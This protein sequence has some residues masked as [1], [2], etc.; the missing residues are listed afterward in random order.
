MAFYAY[1][2]ETSDQNNNSEDEELIRKTFESMES[3][4]P[5]QSAA[6]ESLYSAPRYT[7]PYIQ[8]IT[9][10]NQPVSSEMPPVP[11]TGETVRKSSK[12]TRRP[13]WTSD[14]ES[15]API[16]YVSENESLPAY[17]TA[18][19]YNTITTPVAV[20]YYT[21][22]PAYFR[23]A[24]FYTTVPSQTPLQMP[25][26]MP[27]PVPVPIP[28]PV[29]AQMP[30]QVPAPV[31]VQPVPE[32]SEVTS[33]SGSI[34]LSEYP[35]NQDD[36]PEVITKKS[37]QT[38][39]YVQEVSI[40]YLQPPS[41]IP[42]GEILIQHEKPVVPPPAPPIV[43]RQQPPMPET[44]APLVIREAPPKPIQTQERK[45]ITLPGR[46]VPPPPRKVIIE[47]L[48][49]L[50]PK[51]QPLIIERWLPFKYAKRKVIYN[52]PAEGEVFYEKPKNVIIQWESPNVVV[53]REY[54][55]LGVVRANPDEYMAN[56][57]T[58]VKRAEELPDFVRTIRPPTPLVLASD[59]TET[60]KILLE[61]DIDALSL[62]DLDKEGLSE[63]KSVVPKKSP[64]VSTSSIV[65]EPYYVSTQSFVSSTPYQPTVPVQ[66]Y[67]ATVPTQSTINVPSQTYITT[68]SQPVSTQQTYIPVETILPKEMIIEEKKPGP[69][70]EQ[71]AMQRKSPEPYVSVPSQ[72][73]ISS[74][75]YF[76]SLVED[77]LDSLILKREGIIDFYEAKEF[78]K[79]LNERMNK[80]YDDSRAERFLES[81]RLNRDT[82]TM[83]VDAF[84][85]AVLDSLEFY[86]I[87][88]F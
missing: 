27:A 63:L 82:A 58:Q 54:K 56:F 52:K 23:Q 61:G 47:R 86:N 41:P 24:P 73:P 13:R 19:A 6:V 10:Q 88:M 2:Y 33:W 45:I 14:F 65:P 11:I 51:P 83:Y 59:V 9:A 34:P 30:I 85:R 8:N 84:K 39:Q 77:V 62:V 75:A 21:N 70:F 17:S 66:S 7:E 49:Q 15:T 32:T 48:P 87:L 22:V 69:T 28:V 37:D 26:T 18:P 20:P 68:S 5:S 72:V 1:Q 42:H 36:N 40:R 78:I 12:K 53:S 81:V 55:N 38:V 74:H 76:T 79:L 46:K 50:P 64:Y 4:M 16:E 31:P 80:S 25:V 71:V 3:Q 60:P 44:P 67:T 29:P 35:V 57:S 43:I